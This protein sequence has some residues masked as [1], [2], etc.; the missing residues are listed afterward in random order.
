M[1]AC[2]SSRFSILVRVSLSSDVI[3]LGFKFSLCLDKKK[4][5]NVSMVSCAHI[6]FIHGAIFQISSPILQHEELSDKSSDGEFQQ[7]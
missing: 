6:D 5:N 2:A 7:R 3:F 1:S 4:N